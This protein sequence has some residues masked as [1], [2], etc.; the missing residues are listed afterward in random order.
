MSISPASENPKSAIRKEARARRSQLPLAE[1]SQ[2]VCAHLAKWPPFR[3]A[4]HILL[5]TPFRDEIDLLPLCQT[6]G[7]TRY[8]LP[9]IHPDSTMHFYP[10]RPG[11]PL[12]PGQYG[13]LEPEQTHPLNLSLLSSN[14]I[15]LTPGLA[16]D[17]EGYRLGYGKGYY[18]RFFA[19]LKANLTLPLNV[20]ITAEALIFDTLPRD[21]WDIPLQALVTEQGIRHTPAKH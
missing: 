16:F 20:G 9:A 4:E 1:L 21:A 17:I 5:Y 13:I 6:T 12:L 15:I 19:A 11:D 14:D 3:Q 8:F 2:A 18:D 10:Y 7:P